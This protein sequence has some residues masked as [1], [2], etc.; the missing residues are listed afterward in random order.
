MVAWPAGKIT[1]IDLVGKNTRANLMTKRNSKRRAS[2]A[3]VNCCTSPRT[4]YGGD[5][6]DLSGRVVDLGGGS[7]ITSS[8]CLFFHC[9]LHFIFGF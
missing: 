7:K 6:T 2:V 3:A 5:E 8:S 9:A 1:R 4:A